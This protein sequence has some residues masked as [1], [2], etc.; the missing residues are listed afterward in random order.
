MKLLSIFSI[1]GTFSSFTFKCLWWV[2]HLAA[3]AAQHSLARAIAMRHFWK[4]HFVVRPSVVPTAPPE[5]MPVQR[6]GRWDGGEKKTR[7]GS[8]VTMIFKFIINTTRWLGGRHPR[9]NADHLI[10]G[11]KWGADLGGGEGGSGR[12][13]G[14][15]G[16][17]GACRADTRC[18]P[19]KTLGCLHAGRTGCVAAERNWCA[20]HCALLHP[21]SCFDTPRLAPCRFDHQKEENAAVFWITSFK[22]CLGH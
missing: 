2:D 19:G 4:W 12:G 15:E 13:E 16:R 11:C 21:Q 8:H 14:G 22:T 18:D 9:Q 1:S 10:N 5:L 17:L 20:L 7:A 3:D 6:T